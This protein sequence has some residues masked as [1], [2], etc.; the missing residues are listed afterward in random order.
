[1]RC[2][3][4]DIAKRIGG[5]SMFIVAAQAVA[6]QVTGRVT[7]G[8][9]VTQI[10]L[11]GSGTDSLVRILHAQPA[12]PVS[13][14]QLRPLWPALAARRPASV[15]ARRFHFAKRGLDRDMGARPQSPSGARRSTSRALRLRR[16]AG[17]GSRPLCSRHPTNVMT[18]LGSCPTYSPLKSGYDRF[19]GSF[20]GSA[21]Y[22]NHGPDAPCR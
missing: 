7:S 21:D 11:G 6:E 13:T 9:I 19:F 22:F 14:G 16:M 2:V 17:S 18:R 12:S 1:M 8:E 3:N 4:D 15:S 5:H 20:G 10:Q